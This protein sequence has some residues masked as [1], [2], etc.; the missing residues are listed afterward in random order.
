[1]SWFERWNARI[2]SGRVTLTRQPLIGRPVTRRANWQAD[3]PPHVAIIDALRQCIGSPSPRSAILRVQLTD[4]LVRY[5]NI[6]WQAG[7]GS[8]AD[9][10]ALAALRFREVHGDIATQ[11]RVRLDPAAPGEDALAAAMDETLVAA[12]HTIAPNVKLGSL[13]SHFTCRLNN[14]LSQLPRQSVV[15]ASI[16]DQRIVLAQVQ[17]RRVTRVRNESFRGDAVSALIALVQRRRLL[18][19]AAPGQPIWVYDECET[20]HWPDIL[21][22]SP[23]TRIGRDGANP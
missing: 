13:Q 10:R 23:L 2:D 21:D 12:L 9:W 16:E 18:N 8:D 4:T 15:F 17:R 6:P 11:W 1:M 5:A 20:R 19:T 22:D 14:T 3:A 7:L